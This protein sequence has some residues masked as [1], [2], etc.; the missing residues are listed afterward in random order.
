MGRCEKKEVE[1]LIDNSM[2]KLNRRSMHG[3]R[4][5][6]FQTTLNVEPCLWGR[7]PKGGAPNL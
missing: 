2:V 5:F 7:S 3:R 4:V 6:I 1:N